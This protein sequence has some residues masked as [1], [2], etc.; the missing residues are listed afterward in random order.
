[1]IPCF[2]LTLSM[3]TRELILSLVFLGLYINF[4]KSELLLTQNFPFRPC[5]GIKLTCLSLL[6]D[7]FIQI[8]QLAHALLQRQPVTVHQLMSFFG[9]TTF[10]ANRHAQLHWLYHVIHSDMLNVYQSP[11]HLFISFDLS[12]HPVSAPEANSVATVSCSCAISS[13]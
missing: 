6:S 7:K 11:T 2:L 9:N 12:S 4:S 13:S 5:V 1:M 10:C 8:Q 3:V